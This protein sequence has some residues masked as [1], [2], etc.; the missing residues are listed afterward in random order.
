MT[1]ERA[2]GID[3]LTGVIALV[4][5]QRNLLAR[6]LRF[7]HRSCAAALGVSVSGF[8]SVHHFLSYLTEQLNAAGKFGVR[9]F[10][11]S[12][13]HAAEGIAVPLR[14]IGSITYL[15]SPSI[16]MTTCRNRPGQ[17]DG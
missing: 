16:A 9:H 10:A 17:P 3:E 2:A 5:A 12:R 13:S 4:G 15:R 1:L 6:Q 14:M 8:N 7:H 11:E